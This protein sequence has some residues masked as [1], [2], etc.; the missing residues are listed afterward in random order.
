VLSD[1]CLDEWSLIND[2]CYK[3]F[4][5]YAEFSVANGKCR[6]EYGTLVKVD[7]ENKHNSILGF[8]ERERFADAILSKENPLKFGISVNSMSHNF[9]SD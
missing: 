2:R 9:G 3:F 5:E 6:A 4:Y 7:S 8:V 1:G